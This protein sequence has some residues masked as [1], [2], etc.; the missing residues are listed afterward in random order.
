MNP[1]LRSK[2]PEHETDDHRVEFP[3]YSLS[4]TK[5][6][7]TSMM[8]PSQIF[9]LHNGSIIKIKVNEWINN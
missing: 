3:I 1:Q 2:T 4:V 6:S 5:T 9:L 7:E 8:W